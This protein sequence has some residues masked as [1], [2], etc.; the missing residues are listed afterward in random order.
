MKGRKDTLVKRE[1]RTKGRNEGRKE[2]KTIENTQKEGCTVQEGR[3]K[4]KN[5]GIE[6]RYT[7]R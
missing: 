1:T 3:S 5:E 7:D 6:G 2:N 4:G